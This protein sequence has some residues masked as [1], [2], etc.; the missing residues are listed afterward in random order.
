MCIFVDIHCLCKEKNLIFTSQAGQ[1]ITKA[2]VLLG[3]VA[4]DFFL[5][6]CQIFSR[7]E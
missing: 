1:S 5:F 7:I 6:R 2:E 4:N 3:K